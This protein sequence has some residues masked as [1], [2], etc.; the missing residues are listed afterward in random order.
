MSS[1]STIGVEAVSSI[2]F[3]DH[4]GRQSAG[5]VGEEAVE[6]VDRGVAEVSGDGLD[7]ENGAGEEFF[8]GT[9]AIL[10]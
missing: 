2:L 8:D 5:L 10:A 9:E 4:I 6:G 1:L 3:P 7:G